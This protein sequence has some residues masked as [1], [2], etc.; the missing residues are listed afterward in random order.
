MV[1]KVFSLIFGITFALSDALEILK[2]L[3][4]SNSIVLE[5]GSSQLFGRRFFGL[6]DG[7]QVLINGLPQHRFSLKDAHLD[8]N[9]W[10]DLLVQFT[11]D[12]MQNIPLRNSQRLPS[13]LFI[14]GPSVYNKVSSS[15]PHLSEHLNDYFSR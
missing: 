7:H 5:F 10:L 1:V 6:Q 3:I 9:H 13:I 15:R 11:L 12:I 14:L 8:E 2:Q 4:L